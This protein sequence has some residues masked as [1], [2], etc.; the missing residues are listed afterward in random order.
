MFCFCLFVCLFFFCF[1]LSENSSIA[2]GCMGPS[3]VAWLTSFV[4]M[5]WLPL[6]EG[7]AGMGRK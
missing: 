3:M 1:F 5:N 4:L 7:P 2:L 6:K